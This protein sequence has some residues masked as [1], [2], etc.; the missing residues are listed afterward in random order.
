MMEAYVTRPHTMTYPRLAG[1]M[2]RATWYFNLNFHE[3]MIKVM[4]PRGAEGTGYKEVAEK[5]SSKSN[6]EMHK[7]MGYQQG[8]GAGYK[9]S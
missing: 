4:K 2:F 8:Y 3:G 7:K 9:E 1:I 6:T 5:A